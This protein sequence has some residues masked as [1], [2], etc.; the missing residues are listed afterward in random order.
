MQ[1]KTIDSATDRRRFVDFVYR[2]YK[3]NV[4]FR[5]TQVYG[6]RTFLH[7]K[8]CFARAC[9]V[10]PVVVEANGEIHCQ[11]LLIV[12]PA[13]P[14]LQ[15]AF[16]ESLPNCQDEVCCLLDEARRE[17]RA[18]GLDR[19]VVGLNG[20]VSYGVGFLMSHHDQPSSFDGRYSPAYYHHYFE[21]LAAQ[22][23]TLS[24][25]RFT[26]KEVRV[27][28]TAQTRTRSSTVFRTVDLHDFRAE[29]MRFGALC[30]QCLAGT[31]LYFERSPVAMVEM[32]RPLRFF[33]TPTNLIFAV[34]DG[35]DVGF[36]FWLP[37][38]NQIFRSGRRHSLL[39]TALLFMTRGRTITR[40]KVNALGV[41]PELQGTGVSLGLI[42]EARKHALKRFAEG[43][44]NFVWDNNRRSSRLCQRVTDGVFKRYCV[45][46]LPATK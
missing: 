46:E 10:R 30:N 8:D 27:P 15:V 1:V 33:L 16:F 26:T 9:H 28:E 43:E 36:I 13:L 19:L 4:C 37:D 45:Y 40:M 39:A 18:L 12:H 20:H 31:H 41:V 24:T 21:S 22:K 35:R 29:M 7:G 14:L 25:Y 6:L 44:T 2:I 32:L 11:A 23:T 5:D 42:A 38:F 3:E 17:A 34:Q